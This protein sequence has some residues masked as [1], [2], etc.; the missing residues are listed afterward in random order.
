[1]PEHQEKYVASERLSDVAAAYGVLAMVATE[2]PDGA[3]EI[4]AGHEGATAFTL[5]IAQAA[6]EMAYDLLQDRTADGQEAIYVPH[7]SRLDLIASKC[8]S[9]GRHAADG[10]DMPEYIEYPARFFPQL[11]VDESVT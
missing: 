10:R 5:V 9:N 1:M 4:I 6:I 2:R 3:A 8:R 11:A 7:D